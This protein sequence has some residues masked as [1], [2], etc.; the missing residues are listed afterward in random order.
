[1]PSPRSLVLLHDADDL[2]CVDA[3]CPEALR[4][5]VLAY[6]PDIHLVLQNRGV[7]HVTPWDLVNR[8]EFPALKALESAIWSHWT[9]H[10]RLEFEGVNLLDIARYRHISALARLTWA[11][12]V[13]RRALECIRPDQIITFE[14]SGAH[15]LDQPVTYRK[16]PLLSGVFRWLAE[17]AGMNVRLLRRDAV[18]GVAPFEDQI[19][20]LGRRKYPF[21]DPEA[22]IDGQPF[23]LF[24]ANRT[25]LLR[26]LPL[27]QAIRRKT[28]CQAVQLYKEADDDL[29]RQVAEHGHF[30]WHEFQVARPDGTPDISGMSQRAREAFEAAGR[31]ACDEL[32]VV[33]DNPYVASHFEFLFGQYAHKMAEHVVAWRR[34]F[35]RCRPAACVANSHAPI[36]DV[37]ASL[38]IPCLGLSHAL[39]MIGQPEWF[40]SLPE[41]SF[42]GAFSELH[43]DKLVQAG[44]S[45]HRIRITGDPYSDG[46]LDEIRR[47]RDKGIRGLDLRARYGIDRKRRIVLI[48][49]GSLGMPSKL[50]HVPIIDWA[51]GVRCANE[52]GRI[53]QRRGEWAFLVKC[54]PRFD[55]PDL[56]ARVNRTLTA[57]RRLKILA[58]EPL[59]DAAVESDAIC[60][61]C[62][63]TSALIET[64]LLD[65]PVMQFARNLVWYDEQQWGTEAWPH[66]HDINA[67]EAE[68]E[69]LFTDPQHYAGRVRQTRAAVHR[70]LG[71]TAGH[72]VDRCMDVLEEFLAVPVR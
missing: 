44:V 64:S 34:F 24:Q 36:Y 45:P 25:D 19:A 29:V 38:G 59:L 37:A 26:Q 31:G 33:F 21:A 8:E 70:Y 23:V 12:Y 5:D 53:A 51:D 18:P 7:E 57:D 17:R 20:K 66:F 54:H 69:K 50:P 49:T 1:M 67:F 62:T 22:A 32:R 14:E 30:V 43:R 11:A 52:L 6:D 41:R 39:M 65:R 55:H 27:I 58:D 3:L 60:I 63:L 4:G 9:Q 40:A 35:E 61:W 72:A 56:Y 71:G 13:L 48:C 42:I 10:A 2:A 28:H 15:G 16:M 68:L 47:S 46:L